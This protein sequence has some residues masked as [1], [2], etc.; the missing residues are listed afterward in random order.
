[1]TQVVFSSPSHAGGGCIFA[2]PTEIIGVITTDRVIFANPRHVNGGCIFAD[3]TLIV[4]PV[5]GGGGSSSKRRLD[6]A[7][8]QFR[9]QLLRED[10]EILAIVMM[11]VR[12]LH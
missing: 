7:N 4:V 5:T 12:I 2:N 3:P 9:R 8:A 1:M 11:A 10:E 6:L